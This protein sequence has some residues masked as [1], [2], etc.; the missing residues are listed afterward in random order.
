MKQF[1]VVLIMVF[2][3][4]PYARS[5]ALWKQRKYEAAIGVGPT[6][7]FGDVGGFSKTEN[8]L[9]FKDFSF[10]Q[11]RFNI[12]GSL[13][14]RIIDNLSVRLSFTYGLLHATDIRGAN[15]TRLY[16]AKSS[17]F[18]PALICEYYFIKSKRE[19]QY[20]YSE[21][22]KVTSVP[23]L[24]VIDV[25]AFTGLGGVSFKVDGNQALIDR[26][27]VNSG[28]SG[29]IPLGIGA[30]LLM[31]PDYCLGIEFG[32]RYCFS[33]YLD[34]FTS[35]FSSSNDVYYVVNFTFTY[36]IATGTNGLPAFLNKRRY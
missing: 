13:K 15:E 14:Y 23:F 26:G 17:I 35:Q 22:R 2:L 19:N 28:F 25:Y 21:G 6:Q 31:Q 29:V 9:G 36:K 4:L 8:I 30:N 27:M 11:T 32:G 1:L 16:D 34:G 20:N 33:D 18:E 3:I 24:S 5:Q 10:K 12:N 7:F